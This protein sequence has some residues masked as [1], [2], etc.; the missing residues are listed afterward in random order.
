MEQKQPSRCRRHSEGFKATV[1]EACCQP[2][3][4]VSEVARAHAVDASLVRKWM[5]SRGAELP[6]R[7]G[8]KVESRVAQPSPSPAG[9]V[10]VQLSAQAGRLPPSASAGSIRVEVRRGETTV[11]IH[12]P[13][14]AAGECGLW[15]GRWLR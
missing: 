12:W 5:A 4:S 2:G 11:Q 8:T 3:A 13:V 6:S 1:V 15:L 14:E 7:R 9:F 10:P